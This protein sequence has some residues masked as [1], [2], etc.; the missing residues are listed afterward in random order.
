MEPFATRLES[1]KI[2]WKIRAYDKETDTFYYLMPIGEHEGKFAKIINGSVISITSWSVV[3]SREYPL[4]RFIGKQ[5]AVGADMFQ[6]DIVE[7]GIENMFGSMIKSIGVVEWGTTTNPLG[8]SINH[9]N[10]ALFKTPGMALTPTVIG[11]IYQTPDLIP[12]FDKDFNF[13]VV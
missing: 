7:Q 8:Y 13:N 4:S 12:N 3:I 5:D 11:N 1:S 10:N 9:P 6:G 2:F